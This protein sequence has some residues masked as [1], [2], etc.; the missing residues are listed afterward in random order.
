[1]EILSIFKSLSE[2]LNQHKDKLN[3][4]DGIIGDADFGSNI[5]R[6]FDEVVKK[7][8]TAFTKDTSLGEDLKATGM[9]LMIKVGGS[10][11]I[12][13]GKA[14]MAMGD[15][16]MNKYD[17]KNSDVEKMLRA[18]IAMITRLGKAVPGDKT[19]LD[20]LEPA[21]NAFASA[22]DNEPLAFNYAAAAA[23]KG[24]ESTIE[25]V[26]KRGRSSYLGERSKGHMDAGALAVALIFEKLASVKV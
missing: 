21:C 20:A 14:V 6:G 11:G 7:G 12:L 18:G 17:V 13:V 1:M 8:Q 15:Q 26:S 19:L 16:V 5:T 4:L 3:E 10:S 9:T 25:M 24:A 2:E 22:K 23:R